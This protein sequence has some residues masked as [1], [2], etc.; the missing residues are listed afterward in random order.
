MSARVGGR[1]TTKEEFLQSL[2]TFSSQPPDGQAI[3]NIHLDQV[4]PAFQPHL[5]N[6]HADGTVRTALAVLRHM[7]AHAR[8]ANW[9]YVDVTDG[10]V[11]YARVHIQ[12]ERLG[13]KIVVMTCPAHARPR[14]LAAVGKSTK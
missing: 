2:F 13:Q 7:S 9:S 10:F 8:L 1:T 5:G 6:D 3:L 4:E 14:I 11:T 12:P